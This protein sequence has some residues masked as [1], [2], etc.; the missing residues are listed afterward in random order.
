MILVGMYGNLVADGMGALLIGQLGGRCAPPTLV[1]GPP[2]SIELG[3]P[4]DLRLDGSGNNAGPWS[5]DCPPGTAVDGFSGSAGIAMD[6]L[7]LQCAPP[8][9]EEAADGGLFVTWDP[10]SMVGPVGGDGGRRFG[11]VEC[12]GDKVA[13]GYELEYAGRIVRLALVCRALE[14]VD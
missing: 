14:I 7:S 10:P 9:I 12:K 1:E 13:T 11:L 4:T 5:L 6:A 2:I 8:R 3:G